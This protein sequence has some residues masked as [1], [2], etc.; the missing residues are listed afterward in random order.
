MKILI[1]SDPHIGLRR[2]ANTTIKSSLALQ[3]AMVSAAEKAVSLA[4][5]NGCQLSICAGDL[6]DTFS[7]SEHVIYTAMPA[8]SETSVILAG[9][10]D[11]ENR[12]ASLG[13]LQFLSH[14][15]GEQKKF[16]VN[17][18][19]DPEPSHLEIP[20]VDIF[21]VPHSPTQELFEASIREAK[22]AA[23]KC[24]G[25]RLLITH[26]NY[27]M[28]FTSAQESTLNLS[29]DQTESLLGSFH[30]IFLGHEH[31]PAE[32][33]DGRVVI[34]G[35]THPTG[36]SDISDKRAIIYEDGNV[37]SLPLWKKEEGYFSGPATEAD[38]QPESVKFFDLEDDLQTGKISALI[39][40]LYKK[41]AYAVRVRGKGEE[42][43]SYDQDREKISL[44][45]IPETISQR[46]K[47]E[48]PELHSIWEELLNAYHQS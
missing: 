10:H 47:K 43:F 4:K 27:Q 29:K 28:G 1:Y 41:G 23:D 48:D 13:S 2:K 24:S 19:N 30:H 31:T 22:E 26:C 11:I 35:N 7:N 18:I 32:H 8:V 40:G 14:L 16:V 37:T 46:L 42:A 17:S 6:F 9:N 45:S 12:S 15:Y 21:L 36:F 25:R 5:E 34:V 20:G 39:S 33:Y 44:A 3:E 38:N